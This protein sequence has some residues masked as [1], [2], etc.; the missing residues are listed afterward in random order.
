MEEPKPPDLENDLKL[1]PES[2]RPP[3]WML[4]PPLRNEELLKLPPETGL[5]TDGM[6]RALWVPR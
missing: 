1:P 6:L 5:P 2:G 3:R 4:L